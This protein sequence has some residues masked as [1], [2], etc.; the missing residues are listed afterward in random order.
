MLSLLE[1][2]PD[3]Q[4]LN[5]DKKTLPKQLKLFLQQKDLKI[6]NDSILNQNPYLNRLIKECE[7][8]LPEIIYDNW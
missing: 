1:L 2:Y 7:L 5:L 3:L 8:F 6:D 4:S